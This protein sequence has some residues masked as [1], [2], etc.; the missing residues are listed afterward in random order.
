[1]NIKYSIPKQIDDL[2]LSESSSKIYKY[3]GEITYNYD[4][5]AVYGIIP[6]NFNNP[7]KTNITINIDLNTDSK[8]YSRKYYVTETP[9]NDFPHIKIGHLKTH[10]GL[11]SLFLVFDIDYDLDKIVLGQN[12][13]NILNL[14]F[15]NNTIG[16]HIMCSEATDEFLKVI[17]YLYPE[18]FLFVEVYGCK[19]TTSSIFF[20]NAYSY[21]YFVFNPTLLPFLCYDVAIIA[22]PTDEV[23]LFLNK[24]T[25]NKLRLSPNY[26]LAFCSSFQ[27]LNQKMYSKS[28]NFNF[29]Y[30]CVSKLNF[31]S[32][33]EDSIVNKHRMFLI[34][35]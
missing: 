21:L 10:L 32:N 29:N 33:L 22:D 34:N 17:D 18:S 5:D 4:I 31:Y 15:I 20:H 3:K 24:E 14:K 25:Y 16:P 11:I 19:Y 9:I 27:N 30:G 12:I 6:R 35:L 13:S 26:Q 2:P 28:T 1:M 23:A 8:I 7:F